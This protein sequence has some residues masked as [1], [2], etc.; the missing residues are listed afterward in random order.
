MKKKLFKS[1]KAIL[2]VL[3]FL[4]LAITLGIIWP[5]SNL[6]IPQ[7]H[8]TV[9]IKSINV[10]DVKTG[11]VLEK[12]NVLIK[13]NRITAIDSLE[14]LVEDANTLLIDGRGKY[15]IPG[16]WDMHTHSNQHSPWLHHPLYIANGVTGIRDMSGQLNQKDSYWVGSRERLKWNAELNANK[17]I[18]P[19]YVLQ[20][21]YQIDGASSVPDGFP[22]FFKLENPEQVDS[23]LQFYKN[24]QVDFIKIYQ[25]I[26]VAS[27]RKLAKR[28]E[29]Y[30]LHIA[31]HKPMF[32][33][34]EEALNLG[35]RS[36]EHGRIFLFESFPEADS[37]KHPENW[38]TNFSKYK[39]KL[40]EDYDPKVAKE[41]MQLMQSKKAYWVPTVQTLKFEAFAHDVD[42]TANPNLKYITAI[43]KKLW[44]DLD[45]K[46][47]AKRNNAE[48][49]KGV[50]ADFYKI[51]MEQV[52]LANAIG[53]PIMAGTDVTDSYTFAG[54]SLHEELVDLT[55]CGLTN[56][57]ALQS[58]TIVPAQYVEKEHH[59]GSIEKG[60]VADLVLLNRNPLK[61]IS[62][63]SE[64][65]GVLM[66]GLYYDAQKLTELKTFTE[67]AASSFHM[68]TKALYS[69]INSPLIRVQF[70]D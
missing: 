48:A 68:N 25:Q 17:R 15:V 33:S 60:K 6:S 30:G 2:L 24:E 9:L 31:G 47:N 41:L 23:L 67:S 58:A 19:R 39:R 10:I 70:A 5:M 8:H 46:N 34:L 21:S 66:N 16:L 28:A 52:E 50:S 62:N 32:L 65:H 69:L 63:T 54:F 57:E 55:K 36:F 12:R 61:D 27:Y 42:Y 56:L 29:Y 43:R 20:S 37:L 38:K 59:Y 26:P 51:A 64:I 14:I 1:L 18:M 49:T 53:V 22:D 13:N 40:I 35:Q 7:K 3:V 45:T 44:W 11:D 4:I